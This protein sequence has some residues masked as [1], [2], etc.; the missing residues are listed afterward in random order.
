MGKKINKAM[1]PAFSIVEVIVSLVITAII[2]GLIFGIFTILNEQL[3]RLKDNNKQ[4]TDYNRLSFSCTKAMFDSET[5]YQ[6][7]DRI[8]FKT[9]NGEEIFLYKENQL[10]IRTWDNYSD[11][12]DIPAKKIILD[13]LFNSEKSKSF[14]K[15]ELLLDLNNKEVPLR[16]YKP[17]YANQLITWKK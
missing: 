14:L 17:I 11:T 1:I 6:V 5:I 7:N 2:V 15:M 8:C 12:F 13:T 10:I 16:F 3:F 9:H 4:V